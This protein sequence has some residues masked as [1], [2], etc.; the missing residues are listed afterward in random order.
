MAL[1]YLETALKMAK[2]QRFKNMNDRKLNLY[3]G[4][5]LSERNIAYE[6]YKT[7]GLFN[8]KNKFLL[9]YIL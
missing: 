3:F 6:Q 8:V 9:L 7:C 2:P 1:C 4:H 5:L